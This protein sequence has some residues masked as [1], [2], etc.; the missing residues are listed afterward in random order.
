MH[1]FL[2]LWSNRKNRNFLIVASFALSICASTFVLTE[3]NF[4]ITKS[5]VC[6]WN[7]QLSLSKHSGFFFW[8]DPKLTGIDL[9]IQTKF[10]FF[11]PKKVLSFENGLLFL[12]SKCHMCTTCSIGLPRQLPGQTYIYG[13]YTEWWAKSY[14]FGFFIRLSI[15]TVLRTLSF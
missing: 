6:Q 11:F 8:S 7:F 9:E 10:I 14:I 3:K 2:S 4:P 1:Y 13:W 5:N 15:I 12:L